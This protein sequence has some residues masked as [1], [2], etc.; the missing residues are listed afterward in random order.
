MVWLY[1]SP[2]PEGRKEAFFLFKHFLPALATPRGGGGGLAPC[3]INTALCIQQASV[4]GP[5]IL[6]CCQN[7]LSNLLSQAS[8]S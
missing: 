5:A 2:I 6:G 1:H 3:E 8:H 4:V 7:L